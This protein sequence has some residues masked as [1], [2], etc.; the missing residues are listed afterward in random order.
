MVKCYLLGYSEKKEKARKV[1]E[2]KASLN[3]A[4][5]EKEK[6]QNGLQAT[7]GGGKEKK[8]K[9][10]FTSGFAHQGLP[11][12]ISPSVF[13]GLR[14]CASV[15]LARRRRAL[16]NE[17]HIKKG[18]EGVCAAGLVGRGFDIDGEHRANSTL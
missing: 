11:V 1:Q 2:D 12:R 6:Y 15:I 7:S 10:K 16:K 9:K 5:S 17:S 18:G 3:F 13:V 8:M 14:A 4:L